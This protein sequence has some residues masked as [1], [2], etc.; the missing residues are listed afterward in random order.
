MRVS[1][2]LGMNEY[3]RMPPSINRVRSSS[4]KLQLP[5]DV[6]ANIGSKSES[7]I[8]DGAV[9]HWYY[10]EENERAVLSSEYAAKRDDR[11]EKVD[12]GSIS[13][14][15]NHDLF[16]D[17]PITDKNRIDKVGSGQITIS[18]EL[19]DVTYERLRRNDEI[20]LQFIYPCKTDCVNDIWLVLIPAR[21]F[22]SFCFHSM[23]K[24]F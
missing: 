10:D 22:D 1:N 8:Y 21:L 18:K 20:V 13:G 12:K 3:G 6:A 17:A 9:V 19:P 23:D 15:S 7:I 11:L 5:K 14:V 16:E 2:Y 24:V 4:N